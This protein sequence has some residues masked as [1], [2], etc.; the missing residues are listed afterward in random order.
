MKDKKLIA[1]VAGSLMAVATIGG[2]I[3]MICIGKKRLGDE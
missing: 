2:V 1:I 3:A